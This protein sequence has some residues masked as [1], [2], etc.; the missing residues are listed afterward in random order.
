MAD[1]IQHDHIFRKYL[2]DDLR[3]VDFPFFLQASVRFMLDLGIWIHPD[4]YQKLPIHEPLAYREKYPQKPIDR[5]GQAHKKSALL[6]DDNSYVKNYAKGRVVSS[7]KV[8]YYDGKKMDSGFWACHIWDRLADGSLS[9]VDNSLFTFVPN[10]VWLPKEFSRLTDHIPIIKDVMKQLSVNLY[11][12]I[13]F[14]NPD[15]ELIVENSWK[16][17]LEGSHSKII[18]EN[19]LPHID[20]YNLMQIEDSTIDIKIRRNKKYA[21]G[22]IEHGLGNL[23]PDDC[24]ENKFGNSIHSTDRKTALDVGTWLEEYLNALS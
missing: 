23:V 4:A 3:N 5:R 14:S 17:L 7:R 21:K 22:L 18:P 6:I 11:K 10:T 20:E 9:N 19:A 13:K 15:L 1:K 24:K 8:S 12:N 2:Q 16:K